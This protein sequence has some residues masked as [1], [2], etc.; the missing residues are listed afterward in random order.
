MTVAVWI[1][2]ELECGRV[3][4]SQRPPTPCLATSTRR[5][6]VEDSALA[7]SAGPPYGRL[8]SVD[9]SLDAIKPVSESQERWN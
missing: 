6:T 1:D 5:A 3:Q 8:E 7:S 4:R 2:R 9:P